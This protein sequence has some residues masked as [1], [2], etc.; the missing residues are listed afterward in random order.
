MS[1]EWNT[2]SHLLGCWYNIHRRRQIPWIKTF[3]FPSH[4]G[5][6]PARKVYWGHGGKDVTRVFTSGRK[7][8]SYSLD[9]RQGGYQILFNG[10]E[11]ILPSTERRKR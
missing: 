1:L 3:L 11:K 4:K 10:E 2:F 5:G 7:S 9:R 6:Y 8:R